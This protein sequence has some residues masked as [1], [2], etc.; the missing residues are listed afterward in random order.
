MQES[1]TLEPDWGKGLS[2][3][4]VSRREKQDRKLYETLLGFLNA[5]KIAKEHE[6]EAGGLLAKLDNN[7]GVLKSRAL[8]A[9]IYMRR[10]VNGSTDN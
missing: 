4:Q 1:G 6:Y 9:L 8:A 3:S 2:R 10:L 5:A 7:R